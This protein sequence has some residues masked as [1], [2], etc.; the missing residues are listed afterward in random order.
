MWRQVVAELSR[1]V[2]LE[3]NVIMIIRIMLNKF[4]LRYFYFVF[5]SS[6]DTELLTL[7]GHLE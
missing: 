6:S 2:Q 3:Q 7:Q 4:V 5:V 1:D